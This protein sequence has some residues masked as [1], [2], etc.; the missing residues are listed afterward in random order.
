MP[1]AGR[2]AQEPSASGAAEMP[3]VPAAGMGVWHTPSTHKDCV[4]PDGAGAVRGEW[5]ALRSLADH[6]PPSWHFLDT[7]RVERGSLPRHW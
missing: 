6:L 5:E 3:P 2:P 4:S 7:S 1:P